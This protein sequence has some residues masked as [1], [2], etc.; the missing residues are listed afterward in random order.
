MVQTATAVKDPIQEILDNIRAEIA[1]FE[2]RKL[3]QFKSELEAFL[4]KKATVVDEYQK[5]YPV[6][7]DAWKKLNSRIEQASVTLKCRF[8]DGQWK[9]YLQ[10]C[11]CDRYQKLAERRDA[12]VTRMTCGVGDLEKTRD[13]KKAELDAAKTYL[14]TLIAN[15]GKS[16]A[17]LAANGKTATSIEGLANGPQKAV[18]LQWLWLDLLPAHV[19]MAPSNLPVGCLGYAAGEEPWV[20][21]T[22]I[23][24]PAEGAAHPVPWLIDPDDY[25]DALDDAWMAY[26]AARDASAKADTAYAAAPDDIATTAKAL[27][28]DEKVRDDEIRKCLGGKPNPGPDCDAPAVAPPS[29]AQTA[30]VPCAEAAAP[31]SVQQ[32]EP[33]P[34]AAKSEP[35]KAGLA[36]PYADHDTPGGHEPPLADPT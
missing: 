36:D 29:P 5:K 9:T 31:A 25:G 19:A 22:S 23:S 24:A 30:P 8:P 11:A 14:D 2:S 34:G 3:V 27:E 26:R 18:G 10:E 6:L 35:G 17:E 1:T 32:P 15:A 20:I 7:V 21:C 28:A 33:G 4:S 12:L 16:D 13:Q